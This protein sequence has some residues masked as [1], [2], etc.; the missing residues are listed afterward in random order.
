[1][2]QKSLLIML[3][4]SIFAI[5]LTGCSQGPSNCNHQYTDYKLCTKCGDYKGFSYYDQRGRYPK[6]SWTIDDY[7]SLEFKAVEEGVYKLILGASSTGLPHDSW[8]EC[9]ED[10]HLY[11]SKG[12]EIEIINTGNSTITSVGKLPGENKSYYVY[13]KYIKEPHFYCPEN[14]IDDEEIKNTVTALNESDNKIYFWAYNLS[15]SN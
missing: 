14:F 15:K 5:S 1:M 13:F 7:V 12:N 11:D 6:I 8:D 9:V 3:A 10:M 4:L 2:K